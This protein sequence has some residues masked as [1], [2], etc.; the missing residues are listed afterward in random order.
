MIF[1]NGVQITAVYF[2]KG[3]SSTSATGAPP[4][5]V[6]FLEIVFVKFDC[7]TR[8]YINYSR[9]TMFLIC[10]LFSTLTTK[11]RVCMKGASKQTS[12]PRILPRRDPPFSN[13][14]IHHYLTSPLGGRT[15]KQFLTVFSETLI[16]FYY[17]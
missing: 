5:F 7:I 16:Y 11:H 17:D 8:I 13:S 1:G 10:T 15:P 3:G 2:N 9:H 12:D 6:I 14:W 4:P